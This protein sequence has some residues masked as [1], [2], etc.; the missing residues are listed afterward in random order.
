M[1][2]YIL[3]Y[4]NLLPFFL[5]MF[6]LQ[7]RSLKQGHHWSSEAVACWPEKKTVTSHLVCKIN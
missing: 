6:L 3:N 4:A 5:K 2:L 7:M 1:E